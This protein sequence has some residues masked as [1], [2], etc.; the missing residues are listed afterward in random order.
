MARRGLEEPNDPHAPPPQALLKLN[1]TSFWE[2]KI[3]LK[4]VEATFL[5]QF[6]KVRDFIKNR[7]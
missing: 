1:L 4:E 7:R 3:L 5:S 6:S 2:K